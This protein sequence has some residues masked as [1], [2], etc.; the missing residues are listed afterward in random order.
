[1]RIVYSWSRIKYR[2]CQIREEM[3][4]LIVTFSTAV[5][6]DIS[7]CT[8]NTRGFLFILCVECGENVDVTQD[9]T[10]IRHGRTWKK[11]PAFNIQSSAVNHRFHLLAWKEVGDSTTWPVGK[12]RE[13]RGKVHWHTK[14]E[15]QQI[16]LTYVHLR[17]VSNNKL[18]TC[19]MQGISSSIKIYFSTEQQNIPRPCFA[20]VCFT[21]FFTLIYTFS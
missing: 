21:P 10:K 8:Q 15:L 18:Q 1:M 5:S 17:A 12:R 7:E 14:C 13:W 20:P 6:H 3:L 9:S 11:S 4:A 19:D 2:T 16:N